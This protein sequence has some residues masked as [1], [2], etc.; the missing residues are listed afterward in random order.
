MKDYLP[1]I[2]SVLGSLISF[3][4]SLLVNRKTNKA[5]L[6]QMKKQHEYDM[7]MQKQ[8]LE[9]KIALIEKE[10]ALKAGTQ[11]ITDFTSKTIDAVYNAEPVKQ[12]LN[13]QSF[14]AF[15]AKRSGKRRK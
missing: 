12:E 14:R 11:M 13:K 8:E 15:T 1:Y 3:L 7:E 4:A 5:Q 2:V 10:Y 9:N 6:E